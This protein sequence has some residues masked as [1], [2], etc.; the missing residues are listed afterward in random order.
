MLQTF[1]IVNFSLDTVQDTSWYPK[2]QATALRSDPTYS[3]WYVNLATPLLLGAIPLGSLLFFN[4]A[5]YQKVKLPSEIFHHHHVSKRRLAQEISLAKILIG[6]VTT[7]IL[8][9]SVR[10]FLDIHEIFIIK[11]VAKC[12]SVGK[13]GVPPWILV[14][15]SISKL[16]VV[17]NSSVNMV[18]YCCLN[19]KFRRSILSCKNNVFRYLSSFYTSENNTKRHTTSNSVEMGPTRSARQQYI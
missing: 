6:I 16:M 9:H 4:C 7:F 1:I 11:E 19:A 3:F 18:I 17:I 14:L 10:L 2:L 5:I 13:S 15:V 12:W 8:C